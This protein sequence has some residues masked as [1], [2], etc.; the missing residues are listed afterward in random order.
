MATKRIK[1]VMQDDLQSLENIKEIGQIEILLS[2]LPKRVGA[3]LSINSLREILNCS[4]AS[5]DKWLLIA[6]NLY[7][8]FRIPP[9]IHKMKDQLKRKKKNYIYGLVY[10]RK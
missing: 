9:Y 4:H 1:R 7:L 8:T 10:V 6:D 3:M 2:M 5:V